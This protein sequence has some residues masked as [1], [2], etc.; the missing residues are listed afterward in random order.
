MKNLKTYEGFFD[1]L[2]KKN[3][4]PVTIQQILDCLFDINE[5]SRIKNDLK[6]NTI[7]G[8]FPSIETVTKREDFN[9]C[10]TE[11]G[12]YYHGKDILFFGMQY[13][14]VEMRGGF[15]NRYNFDDI[16]DEEVDALMKECQSMLEGYDCQMTFFI[17]RGVDEGTTWDTEFSDINKMISKTIK[18]MEYGHDC[19]RNIIVKIKAL[20][21][22]EE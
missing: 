1:F 3:Y 12:K 5:E 7:D 13:A 22:I 6:G 19:V 9:L 2:K 15:M 21:G 8:I 16:S 11:E 18:K 4:E 17:G 10:Q 14:P 20:G